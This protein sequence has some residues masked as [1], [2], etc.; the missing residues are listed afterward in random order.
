MWIVRFHEKSNLE[1]NYDFLKIPDF[2]KFTSFIKTPRNWWPLD[3]NSRE[4]VSPQDPK[5]QEY[6]GFPE[7][8]TPNP[9]FS[10]EIFTKIFSFH[11][12]RGS[13]FSRIPG[14]FGRQNPQKCKN[15]WVSRNSR[16]E[17]QIFPGKFLSKF[18]IF[19]KF[20]GHPSRNSREF[21]SKKPRK[22]QKYTGFTGFWG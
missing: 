7:F 20:R 9:E 18:G 1:K 14:N 8:T 19:T 21:G 22:M 5:M 11:E 16:A 12:N 2:S 13:T 15:I 3:E 4:F 17:M 6:M 10:R